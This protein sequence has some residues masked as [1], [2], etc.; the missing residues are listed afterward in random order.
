MVVAASE[1]ALLSRVARRPQPQPKED[2]MSSAASIHSWK[3]TALYIGQFRYVE[4]LIKSTPAIS[5]AFIVYITL[6]GVLW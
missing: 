5:L 6:K 2:V 4:F 3:K 1:R